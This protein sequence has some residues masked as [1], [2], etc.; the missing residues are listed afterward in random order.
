[1]RYKYG[2]VQVHTKA[3]QA[4]GQIHTNLYL[5]NRKEYFCRV[6]KSKLELLRTLEGTQGT[7][8]SLS[9]LR[10]LLKVFPKDRRL[11]FASEKKRITEQ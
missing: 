9:L 5:K 3:V 7:N 2:Y 8:L 10:M 11:Y 1:M 6:S 4:N